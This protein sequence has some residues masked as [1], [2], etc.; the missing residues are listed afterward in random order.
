MSSDTEKSMSPPKVT[1]I[2]TQVRAKR[3][4]RDCIERAVKKLEF[5]RINS[6]TDLYLREE[7]ASPCRRDG[8]VMNRQDALSKM[9]LRHQ[10]S[11]DFS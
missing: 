4:T 6:R 10:N 2:D 9:S 7:I 8:S 1:I 5:G 11:S 3:L